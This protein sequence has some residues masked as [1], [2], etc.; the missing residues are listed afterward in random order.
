MAAA[1]L[2]R[3]GEKQFLNVSIILEG[4]RPASRGFEFG[5]SNV[6][7]VDICDA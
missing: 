3:Q 7:P 6:F 5:V 1:A 2:Y 4:G